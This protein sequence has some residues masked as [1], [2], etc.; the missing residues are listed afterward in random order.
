METLR[1]DADDGYRLAVDG[2]FLADNARVGIEPR[3]P[4]GVTQNKNGTGAGD[5]SFRGKNETPEGRLDVYEVEEIT[6]HVER[7]HRL[8]LAV[9]AQTVHLIHLQC[10]DV[11]KNIPRLFANL[12]IVRVG[13]RRAS[14]AILPGRR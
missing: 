5:L 7:P 1:G 2:G 4:V 9:H 8:A 3:F 12:E 13:K 10:G 14:A 6:S 11:R